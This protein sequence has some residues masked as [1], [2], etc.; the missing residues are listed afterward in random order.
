[1]SKN[2]RKNNIIFFDFDGTIADTMKQYIYL[3]NEFAKKNKKPV[4]SVYDYLKLRNSSFNE[5]RKKLGYNLL[6]TFYIAKKLK[7]Q[8]YAAPFSIK[9]VPGIIDIINEMHKRN[10]L[11]Y[12]VSSNTKKNIQKIL[13]AHGI[14]HIEEIISTFR[15]FNKTYFIKKYLKKH[16]DYLH[17]FLISDEY[18][19]I[20]AANK[21]DIISLAVTWG[22]NNFNQIHDVTP[23][24]IINHPSQILTAIEQLT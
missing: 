23:N 15:G 12:I 1:M 20:R 3:Y 11:I 17:A 10:F 24:F 19:D 9:I 6:E 18:K 7:K 5:V 13:V 21:L 22:A 8:L 4:I 2:S 16:K 14:N